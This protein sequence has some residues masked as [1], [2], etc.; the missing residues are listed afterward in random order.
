MTTTAITLNVGEHEF[1]FVLDAPVVSKYVNS[2]TQSNKVAPG[3]N[4]LMN[5]V[6]PEQKDLLK[7]FLANPMMVMQLSGALLEEY[8]PTVE[9]TVKK[10]EAT[11]SA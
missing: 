4:L 11:L 3:N 8:S 2:L 10:R 7:P 9:I 6:K 1:D 5:T